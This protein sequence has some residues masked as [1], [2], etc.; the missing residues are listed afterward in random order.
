MTDDQHMTVLRTL[1]N[2]LGLSESDGN[3]NSEQ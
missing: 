2:L 3:D 1:S